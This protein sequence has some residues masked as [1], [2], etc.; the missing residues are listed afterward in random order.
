M[1]EL[2]VAILGASGRMGRALVAALDDI[3]VATLVG[4]T[5]SPSSAWLGRD[6]GELAGSRM[7]GVLL[8]SDPGVA[9][10][11]AQVAVDFSLP[12]AASANVEACVSRKCA[13]IIGVTGHDERARADIERASREI[14][15][16]MAPNMSMGVN[17]LLRLV[18]LAAHALDATYDIE[19]F[20]AHHRNKKDAPSGTALA[21]GRAAAKGRAVEL[22]DVAQYS[23]RGVSAPRRSG[24]IGFAVVRGG[25]IVGDHTVTFAGLGERIELTHRASDRA[26]FARGAL[27]A[28]QWVAGRGPG[29]YSMQDVLGLRSDW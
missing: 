5:C 16:V 20:E 12:E 9:M 4:A 7:R 26:A 17:L 25:D 27:K 22:D 29:L 3:E 19:V 28:V 11:D 6:V 15:V 8:S 14:P 13:L 21:L 24:S 10:R 2:R 1:N 23:Q 18:E